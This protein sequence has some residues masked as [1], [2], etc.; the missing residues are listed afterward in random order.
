ME[1]YQSNFECVEGAEL[2]QVTEPV[3]MQMGITSLGHRK[4]L[5]RDIALPQ[6]GGN[7]SAYCTSAS[8]IIRSSLM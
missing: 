2:L 4:R 1:Q 5:L 6:L 8:S 3:L 7:S